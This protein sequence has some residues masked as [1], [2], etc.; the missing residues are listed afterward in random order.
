MLLCFSMQCACC[1]VKVLHC[2]SG[3]ELQ[4]WVTLR[5]AAWSCL[6]VQSLTHLSFV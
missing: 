6:D 1:S 2:R 3:V 5:G 4:F